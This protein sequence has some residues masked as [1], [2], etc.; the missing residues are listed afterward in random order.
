[1]QR[2]Q[3]GRHRNFRVHTIEAL[4]RLHE[5]DVVCD[6]QSVTCSL[7]VCVALAFV[8]PWLSRCH[9]IPRH[10]VLDRTAVDLSRHQF[11]RVSAS[12]SQA[13]DELAVRR[14]RQPDAVR[15]SS[16]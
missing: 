6:L 1:M 8:P 2:L 5:A 7:R 9:W 13:H 10:H 16:W 12:P 3:A 4:R 14:Q 15:R 11:V